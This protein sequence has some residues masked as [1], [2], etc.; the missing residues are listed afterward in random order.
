M[1]GPRST[2]TPSG[3]WP[4]VSR[5]TSQGLLRTEPDTDQYG[6]T[7]YAPLPEPPG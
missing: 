7:G 6:W 3:T 5:N 2:S 4:R 1:F